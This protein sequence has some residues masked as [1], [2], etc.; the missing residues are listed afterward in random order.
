MKRKW[1]K[2]FAG[3]TATAIMMTTATS[4][5]MAAEPMQE[6]LSAYDLSD[7]LRFDSAANSHV[8]FER[9]F[10]S[11][12]DT[13]AM[14]VKV[15][16]DNT[17]RQVILGNYV[18]RENCFSIELTAD[19]QLRYVEYVYD[20]STA[21]TS[22]DLRA[23]AD[24]IQNGE[25]MDLAIVRD[26]K[27][28][29]VSIIC[30]G[31]E[32]AVLQM[33]GDNVLQ[34]DPPLRSVHYLGTDA[35]KQYWFDGEIAKLSL[36]DACLT[37]EQI[38]S[39]LDEPLSGSE[40]DLMHAYVLDPDALSTADPII[41]DLKAGGINGAAEGFDLPYAPDDMLVF[42]SGAKSHVSFAQPFASIPETIAMQVKVDPG[43]STRQV[44]MGNYVYQKNCFS[45]ELTADQQL[46]Y[47]EY[48]YDGKT[49][50]TSIDMRADVPQLISGQWVDLAVIRNVE[51]QT[52]SFVCDGEVVETLELS[53]SN[54]L[55][56]DV[57]LSDAHYLGTDARKQYWFDGAMSRVSL[58]DKPL[59]AA[60]SDEVLKT[61]LNGDEDGLMHAYELRLN[62]LSTSD[63]IIKDLKASGINATASGFDFPDAPVYEKQGTDFSAND[64]DLEMRSIPDEIPMSMEVWVKM[65]PDQQGTR[66]IITGNY[67][68]AYYNGIPLLNFEITAKGEPRMYWYIDNQATDYRASGVNVYNGKWT[69]IAI[70]CAQDG[71]Q[72]LVTTYINGEEAHAQRMDFTPVMLSQPMKIG[73]DSRFAHYFKGEMADLRLWS[74]TR[75]AEEIASNFNAVVPA[76]EE[77][78]LGNWLLD[79]SDA[80]G[81]YADRSVH[82]NDAV[83][84]WV[85]DDLFAHAEDGYESI[86]VIPDT[87]SLAAWAPESFTQLTTW[88]TDHA[89]ELGIKLVVH[90]GDIVNERSSSAEWDAA[91][92]SMQVMDGVI[93]YVFSPGNH[94]TQI[95]KVD[96]VWHGVRDTAGMNE[97]FPYAV[98]AQ[99][100]TFGGAYEEGKMDNTYSYFTVA[101]Q[102]IMTISLEQNPRD[103]V[104]AWAN[105]VAADNPDRKIIVTTHEYM[106]YD[107]DPTTEASQDHLP[108]IGGSNCG[109]QLWE[110][111]GSKHENI[112]A[113]I[114]GHVG[115]PDIVMREAEGENGNM[116]QQILCDAQFMDRD[117]ANNGSGKGLGM[118]M[119]LS[120]KEGSNEMQVRWYSTVREQFFRPADQFTADIQLF[121]DH[122]EQLSA[123]ISE[124]EQIDLGG[125]TESSAQALRDALQAAKAVLEDE[126]ADLTQIDAA[127][128]A[129]QKAVDALE[130]L[131]QADKQMLQTVYDAVSHVLT[132]E[133]DY[134][135]D[136][137]WTRFVQ[138]LEEAQ[139]VLNDAHATQQE[140][141]D[142]VLGLSDAY[143]RLRLKPDEDKLAQLQDFLALTKG[144]ERMRYS[145]D[146]L[147]VIDETAAEAERMLQTM[148][149]TE[150]TFE[151]FRMDMD[152]VRA[153]IENA[154]QESD[155]QDEQEE[156]PLVKTDPAEQTSGAK[157]GAEDGSARMLEGM[158][159]AAAGIMVL[160]RK[161]KKW[162]A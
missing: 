103:E 83:S 5:I 144:I 131:E 7:A 149:F 35:R 38:I 120:F 20:G 156:A 147:S 49:A 47:V 14:Q 65:D 126:E 142:A 81:A 110:K 137:A 80:Q 46:R 160:N 77:G 66:S 52:V 54:Q 28:Q 116:V 161:H 141:N 157:T 140:V 30:N 13:I 4:G 104:L 106:Y 118:V 159:A 114:S 34:E 98:Y 10:A 86:A 115:Y 61:A 101:G 122:R 148:D 57:P 76:D 113:I 33:E 105:Q 93:P 158:I 55:L 134:V 117:D 154:K 109:Q 91:K 128:G 51:E 48:V 75:S 59:S 78:L 135:H 88:L 1:K 42:D 73:E 153:L 99:A 41:D 132:Q 64:K 139:A 32:I 23:E 17:S 95:Q 70:T 43:S 97:A 9:P 146:V 100:E 143:S 119:L 69:H 29:R 94:D 79:Q 107:G 63:P 62:E 60:Q 82:D 22:I 27:Q 36:W 18:Y 138:E 133:E 155:P 11:I 31:E 112:I 127:Y 58:W 108:F 8:Q 12:P 96:G 151:A 162:Q 19:Q 67:Y 2:L 3:V 72:V 37:K 150:E 124:A 92:K 45:L 125:Y 74:T 6:S 40:E 24:E 26:V 123:L 71:D 15:D 21:L 84:Y 25:W 129:L 50:L 53:G 121:D 16:P 130:E 136:E 89:D 56:A 44:L 68:D 90:V 145:A 87:Q 39:I 111:F 85:D 102:K 152:V